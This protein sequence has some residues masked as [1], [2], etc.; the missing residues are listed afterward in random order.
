MGCLALRKG[1]SL[2]SKNRTD[3]AGGH[4]GTT[5]SSQGAGPAACALTA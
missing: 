3:D 5:I 1:Q 2:G 4:Q